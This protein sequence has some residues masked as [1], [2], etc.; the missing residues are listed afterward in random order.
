MN[1]IANLLNVSLVKTL[2]RTLVLIVGCSTLYSTTLVFLI[3]VL[4]KSFTVGEA[5]ILAELSV[6]F[7]I[8]AILTVFSK[9]ALS[10]FVVIFNI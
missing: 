10:R 2:K 9:V 7:G 5:F 6:L 8:D 1:S 4:K 3:N